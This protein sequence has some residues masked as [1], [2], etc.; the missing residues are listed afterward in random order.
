MDLAKSIFRGD[1]GIWA[2]F[3]LLC[4]ISMVEVFSSSIALSSTQGIHWAPIMKH[5]M[6]LI[7]GLFIVILVHNVPYR[8][9]SSGMILV[10]ISFIFLIAVM[11]WGEERGNAS[12]WFRVMGF[13]F[14]PSELAKLSI[15]ISVAFLL[16]RM[17][18][19]K[20]SR[21]NTFK[22]L[23]IG[24][25]VMCFTIMLDNLS[26][27]VLLFSVCMIMMIIGNV[28]LLKIGKLL[29]PVI[30][31]VAMMYFVAPL[32]GR[33]SENRDADT[34]QTEVSS[35]IMGAFNRIP[36]WRNRIDRFVDY[37]VH[38]KSPKEYMEEDKN[39]QPG[40]ARI[41][42]ARGG[43]SPKLPGNSYARNFLP[44]ANSDFIYAVIIE[45]LGIFGGIFVIGLYVALL[46]R[47]GRLVQKCRRKFPAFLLIGCAL[48]IF[49]Q[50]LMH[51]LVC[52]HLMPVTGQPLPLISKGGTS[53]CITCV[54]FGIMLSISRTIIPSEIL[55]DKNFVKDSEQLP[56]NNE[57]DDS[58]N[59]DDDPALAEAAIKQVMYKDSFHEDPPKKQ[60]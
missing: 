54:Y 27:A 52:V 28:S 44:E 20:V 1:K 16:S 7:F 15:I 46:V 51:M 40:Y 59:S 30:G 36:T 19:T 43:F 29:L 60:N 23:M 58:E 2:I 37:V 55:K 47:C 14:Q 3:F 34:E 26:T 24:I 56:E 31:L 35:G 8:W 39:F 49:C 50:A 42:I 13:Q 57:P 41:A 12:R 33:A 17:Q 21:D 6:L 9:Y 10:P 4:V 45:E 11:I 18:D 32:F 25:S 5:F 22:V 48:I 53:L 38:D